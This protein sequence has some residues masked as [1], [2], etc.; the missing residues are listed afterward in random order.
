M[1]IKLENVDEQNQ[2]N[3]LKEIIAQRI[4]SQSIALTTE[5]S[6]EEIATDDENERDLSS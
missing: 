5:K 4:K 6:I 1:S 2:R 3:Q